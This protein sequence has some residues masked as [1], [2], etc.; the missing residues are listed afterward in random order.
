MSKQPDIPVTPSTPA[1]GTPATGTPATGTVN[2][3]PPSRFLQQGDAGMVSQADIQDSRDEKSERD[4]RD[5]LNPSLARE[6]PVD[7]G[8]AASGASEGVEDR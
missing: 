1:T 3:P 5:N 2:P 7:T 6:E 4:R 8:E